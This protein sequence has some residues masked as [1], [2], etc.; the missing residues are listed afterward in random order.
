MEAKAGP[1]I[2][3]CGGPTGT[4]AASPL[5]LQAMWH[6]I[7]IMKQIVWVG[8]AMRM[9]IV[10]MGMML[11]MAAGLDWA[12]C[13][14]RAAR[15]ADSSRLGMAEMLH[16]AHTGQPSPILPATNI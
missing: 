15:G 16:L 2:G 1:L 13:S 12:R 5:P 8:A 9:I 11:H 4:A 7:M 10:V 6:T 3:E 14:D